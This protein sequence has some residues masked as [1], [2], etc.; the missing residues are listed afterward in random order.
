MAILFGHKQVNKPDG[1]TADSWHGYRCGHCGREVSGAVLAYNRENKHN[2]R[3]TLWLQCSVCYKG[4]TQEA[5]GSVAPGSAFGPVVEGLPT[6]VEEAYNE[7]RRC[8]SVSAFTAAE[9]ICRKILMH[10][11]VDKGAAE[12]KT[13]SF[14]IDY[15]AGQGYVTPPM[16]EWVTLIKDHGNEAAHRLE[17]PERQRAE[18]TVLFTAQLLRSVYEMGHLASRFTPKI[19][20]PPQ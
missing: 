9:G 13:F 18:G 11:A 12:G 15:L 10:V 19:V 3:L 6:A 16:R 8:M 1:S 5:D 2:Q 4:T 17:P 7:A 20:P 14:Y